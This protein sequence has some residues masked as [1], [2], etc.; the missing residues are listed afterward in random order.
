MTVQQMLQHGLSTPYLT[1]L[2]ENLSLKH[3]MYFLG[4]KSCEKYFSHVT[5]ICKILHHL[6]CHNSLTQQGADHHFLLQDCVYMHLHMVVVSLEISVI[7]KFPFLSG[8]IQNL[9]YFPKIPTQIRHCRSRLY[10][11]PEIQTLSCI[12]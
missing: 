10:S 4:S 5:E 11:L 2:K 3:V 6:V 1:F 8:Y 12:S 9:V 7:K